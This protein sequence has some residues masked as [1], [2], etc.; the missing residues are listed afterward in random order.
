M[1]RQMIML[2]PD[3]KP[4]VD[5]PLTKRERERL[6]PLKVAKI[7]D[8]DI[9]KS[10]AEVDVHR[11][12]IKKILQRSAGR[13]LSQYEQTHVKN[14]LSNT[15]R[16]ENKAK[17]QQAMS[18]C[19]KN[20]MEVGDNAARQTKINKI[21]ARESKISCKKVKTSIKTYKK[22][23]PVNKLVDLVD[24]SNF[25]DEMQEALSNLMQVYNPTGKASELYDGTM[26]S[27]SSG[28][29]LYQDILSDIMSEMNISNPDDASSQ[30]ITTGT[31]ELD[32]DTLLPHVP[33]D[34]LITSTHV[35]EHV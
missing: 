11:D 14:A 17:T 10:M 8:E 24:E 20:V 33:N 27:G 6:N 22:C 3:S 5:G 31:F 13:K 25:G 2:N 30:L 4:R 28:A 18:E 23:T 29:L 34:V 15:V 26:G 32:V 35:S 16:C 21:V 1:L 9:S 19:V 12:V 7:N